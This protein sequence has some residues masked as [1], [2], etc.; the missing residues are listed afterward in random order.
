MRGSYS[1]LLSHDVG[2]TRNSEA[3]P[4]YTSDRLEE[5]ACE[6]Y[7]AGFHL[8]DEQKFI[9]IDTQGII[10]LYTLEEHGSPLR[11]VMYHLQESVRA[12]YYLFHA[13]PSFHGATACPDL[14]PA[15]VPSPESQIIVLETLTNACPVILVIDMVIFSGKVL[16]SETPVEVPWS[17]W[18]PQYTCCFRH[19]PSCRI[20]VFGSKIAYALP[21]CAQPWELNYKVGI[22]QALDD[23]NRFYVYILDF[24][25][26][27]IARSKN[28]YDP[29]LPTHFLCKPFDHFDVR[30]ISTRP[31]IVTVCRARF[32]PI[33]LS[34]L[35]LEHDRLTLTWLRNGTVHIQVVSSTGGAR[36]GSC[37]L[38]Y[39]SAVEGG[40][41]YDECRCRF[42][43]T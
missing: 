38:G 40:G 8:V 23:H 43:P 30:S 4:V 18:G 7:V 11:R 24:N 14:E 32:S 13:T 31:Y 27:A 2:S 35:F 25:Q 26:R 16:H 9:V 21:R 41:G 3:Q 37:A 19:H 1:C 39:I 12:P 34:G 33:C 15:Y 42:L 20:S 17:E 29:D 36:F 28:I 22:R 6:E 10:T 5:R